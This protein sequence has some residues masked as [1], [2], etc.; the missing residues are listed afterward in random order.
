MANDLESSSQ[1]N[2]RKN[3]VEFYRIAMAKNTR[4]KN[5]C[6]VNAVIDIYFVCHFSRS[7]R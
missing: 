6:R 1:R 7:S 2:D 3:N 4:D 5:S